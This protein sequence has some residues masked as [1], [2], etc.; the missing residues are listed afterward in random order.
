M[1]GHQIEKIKPTLCP[2]CGHD[3]GV[4]KCSPITK[5]FNVICRNC[6]ARGPQSILKGYA[7]QLWNSRTTKE[8]TIL[9]NN[10]MYTSVSELIKLL[11]KQLPYNEVE[12]L[13]QTE[14]NGEYINICTKELVCVEEERSTTIIRIHNRMKS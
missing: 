10:N 1:D 11:E 6:F 9:R 7:I 8:P 12:F 14:I 2:F 5:K 4:V 3:S 13:V